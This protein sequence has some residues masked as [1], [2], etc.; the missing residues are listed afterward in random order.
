MFAI[1]KDVRYASNTYT[2]SMHTFRLLEHLHKSRRPASR[3]ASECAM[4]LTQDMA[5]GARGFYAALA[6]N[7]KSASDS[8]LTP[9]LLSNLWRAVVWTAHCDG[10]RTMTLCCVMVTAIE[11]TMNSACS[12]ASMLLTCLKKKAGYVQ[13]AMPRSEPPLSPLNPRCH[14]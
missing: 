12:R 13:H 3:D 8:M 10:C 2:P 1:R 9:S 5:L 14:P 4:K 6:A 11:D 7:A